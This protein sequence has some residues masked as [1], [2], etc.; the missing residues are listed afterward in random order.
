MPQVINTNIASL[1]A[2][3]NLNASQGSLATSL[4]RLSSGL[5]INSAKDDAAGMAIADRM[6]S[7]VRGL[8][9][10]TRNAYDGISLAQ[11][12]EG[13]LGE[14]NNILQRIRELAIQSANATN[15]AS[16][17]LALQSEV[18]QLISE[19]DRIAATTSFN[20][21]KL[22]DGNFVA[23]NFQVGA[24]ANQ[25]I[26]V[27]VSGADSSTLGI[28]KATANNDVA[29][30]NNAVG[31]GGP[32]AT[33]TAR[34]GTGADFATAAAAAVP[35]QTITVTAADGTTATF[36][37]D[38]D[39]D[40]SA[41]GIAAGLTGLAGVTSVDAENS[42]ELDVSTATGVVAGNKVTFTLTGDTAGTTANVSF[43]VTD[44]ATT[45]L[46]Q[47]FAN[48]ISGAALED[49]AVSVDGGVVTITS[50]TGANVGIADLTFAENSVLSLGTF[51]ATASIAA[52]DEITFS[53]NGTAVAYSLQAGDIANA[54]AGTFSTAFITNL[55][56]A[57]SGAIG[58]TDFSV[59]VNG[60]NI[61]ITAYG[62]TVELTTLAFTS[63][64]ATD[65]T[66]ASSAPGGT[67][68]TAALAEGDDVTATATAVT[69]TV[70]FGGTTIGDGVTGNAIAVGTVEV[71]LATGANISS[72]VTTGNAF[73]VAANANASLVRYGVADITGGNYVEAQDIMINGQV[74][75]T[76]S[77]K[78]NYTA[79]Q[80]AALVNAVSDQTGVQATARTTATIKNLSADGVVSM[81][82]NGVDIS[83][84]VTTSNL[85]ELAE[86]INSKTG[87][88]GIV[89]TLDIT[90]SEISLLQAEGED[91]SILDFSSSVAV[92]DDTAPTIVTLDIDGASGTAARL[93]AG[94]TTLLAGTQDSTV[95]GGNVEF[96][97]PGGYFSL[98]SSID[99]TAGGLFDG[100]AEQLQASEK[101]AL[102]T[103]D[104]STAAGAT[105]AID[106]ADGALARI[107]GIRADLGAVQN[108]FQ[109][110]ISNLTTSAE[111]L[112]AARSRIQD[113]DFAAETA[114]LTR[115]Q[116]LQQA[117]VA[118]LAQANQLPQQVLQLLQR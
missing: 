113:A 102:N 80:V 87:A 35:D 61:E 25:T 44:L 78:E 93:V 32:V 77:I 45:S 115:A 72:D 41:L 33:T 104:I 63:V 64:T 68:T 59:A 36:A 4:Q 85:T 84:N 55:A 62:D 86:A 52:G 16:D 71:T 100:E 106:I 2:Q 103:V 60:G 51:A 1:N 11:I 14:T 38:S 15:S 22:L 73:G 69:D 47:Q 40:R 56:G 88:T 94:G 20:G 75:K 118:M 39:D 67:A 107:N 66:A 98:A 46:A 109:S 108:R 111:N 74:S 79:T 91:I 9:Q 37:I 42:V 8:N 110:T 95:I 89:A 70:D 105:R 117:G 27:S 92:I 76:V 90:K 101:Q 112:T 7:Q 30:I 29:G 21:L 24:E 57:I 23:Q 48:A 6:S 58:T 82:L 28:N 114:N 26:S 54:S 83:A 5:R 116:I 34:V 49:F 12:A 97:S 31:S 19:L 53:I 17:R 96:K 3:R 99:A 10:A 50:A 65:L 13:A 18:N 81:T 43:T